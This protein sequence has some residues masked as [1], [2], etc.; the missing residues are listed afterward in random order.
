[1]RMGFSGYA[2][3]A[4]EAAMG[5]RANAIVATQKRCGDPPDCFV[6]VFLVM[7]VIAA[8]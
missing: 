8:D 5:M 2:E 7:T 6:T 1:M 4:A 3:V